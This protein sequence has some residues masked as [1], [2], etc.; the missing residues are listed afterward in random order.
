M[1]KITSI[2]AAAVLSTGAYANVI[3]PEMSRDGKTKN[4]S[5]IATTGEMRKFVAGEYGMQTSEPDTANSTE[6]EVSDF[7]LYGA[8]ANKKISAELD[9]DMQ[10]TEV[11]NTETDL[12]T[13]DLKAAYRIND[14]IALGLGYKSESNGTDAEFI[15]IAGA[16]MMKKMTFGLSYTIQDANTDSDG[17]NGL[18]T[19]GVGQANKMMT[20]EAGL[21]LTL[22]DKDS[23]VGSRTA[24]FAGITKM[25]GQVELD[26][27]LDYVTG[28]FNYA[29]GDYDSLDLVV[30]AE[31]LVGKMYYVT[32]GLRYLTTD[33]GSAD[34]TDLWLSGDFGYRAN[35][36]DAT[37]GVDYA[38][39]KESGDTDSDYMAWKINVAYMF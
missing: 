23:G 37:I 25:M 30:D 3:M 8:W 12:D 22:D 34:T 10:T 32:P 38:V 9:Y 11:G 31:Y 24:L 4:T 6:T 39:I 33:N 18:I 13:I 20:W 26:A 1:K 29:G 19:L 15:E 7:N 16:Y 2:I 35:K 36:I 17:D 5:A 27:T 21:K 14:K 28:D